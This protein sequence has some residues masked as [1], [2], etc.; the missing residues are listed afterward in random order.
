MRT[1]DNITTIIKAS[2][3]DSGVLPN[4]KGDPGVSMFRIG[5]TFELQRELLLLKQA[6]ENICFK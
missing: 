4:S 3:N 5:L 6:D 2:I 1:K